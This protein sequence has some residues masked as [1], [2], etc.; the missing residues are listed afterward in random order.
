MGS[1]GAHAEFRRA[2]STVRAVVHRRWLRPSRS[3]VDGASPADDD[4]VAVGE[5]GG[6]VGGDEVVGADGQALVGE[7]FGDV[8]GEGVQEC[9]ACRR[10]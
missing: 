6:G 7:E 1:L 2:S 4:L 8:V 9:G 10:R 3:E 5:G